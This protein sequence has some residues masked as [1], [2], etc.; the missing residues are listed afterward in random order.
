MIIDDAEGITI[1]SDKNIN[2][3]AAESIQIISGEKVDMVA[4]D[5]IAME[6]GAVKFNLSEVIGM[7]GSQVRLD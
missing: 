3:E 6:Q 1:I 4:A 7:Q 5:E 2:I